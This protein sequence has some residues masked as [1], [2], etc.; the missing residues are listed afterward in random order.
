MTFWYLIFQLR[1]LLDTVCIRGS[2]RRA[3]HFQ[4][5]STLIIGH[6]EK[7][8]VQRVYS[9]PFAYEK[10]KP[11]RKGAHRQDLVFVRPPDMLRFKLSMESVWF[12]KVLLFFTFET[13]TD[14]GIKKHKCAFVSVMWEYEGNQR[15][16]SKLLIYPNYLVVKSK[17]ILYLL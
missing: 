5:F 1:S 17:Y 6:E 4:L 8:G 2:A 11:V 14:S 10:T 7:E 3:G 9:Y 15:P 13:R 16:G 12:C